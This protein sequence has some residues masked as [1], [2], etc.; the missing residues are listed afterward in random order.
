MEL[1]APKRFR[2]VDAD[3]VAAY[4]GGWWVWDETGLTRIRGRELIALEEAIDTPLLAV[5][6]DLHGAKFDAATIAATMAAMWIGM[7]RAG[8]PIAWSEFNPAVLLTEWQEV[9]E[10]PLDSGGDPMPDS[11][12]SA[13]QTAES[14]TS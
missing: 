14:A 3:D 8:H 5:M 9:P 13:P 10:A 11:G 7:H 6:R 12:S 4:G 2:F 1:W